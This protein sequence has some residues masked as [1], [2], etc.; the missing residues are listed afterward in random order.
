MRKKS[1][2]TGL[3]YDTKNMVHIRNSKQAAK[4]VANGCTLFDL[5]VD[6]KSM[7]VYLFDREE[8]S[9]Y[10]ARWLDGSL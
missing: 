4:Y 3:W 5:V 2:I 6:E 8:A 1:V 7:F 10:L 9:H